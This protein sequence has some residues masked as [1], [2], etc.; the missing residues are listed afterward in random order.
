MFVTG[1]VFGRVGS[2]EEGVGAIGRDDFVFGGCDRVFGR[3]LM[4][5]RLYTR[6]LALV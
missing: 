4:T 5:K 3:V 2:G 1:E 6:I